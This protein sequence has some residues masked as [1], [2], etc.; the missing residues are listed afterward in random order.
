MGNSSLKKNHG[1][2][3]HE[4]VRAHR[5]MKNATRILP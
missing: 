5:A 4:E 2:M 3:R 1:T